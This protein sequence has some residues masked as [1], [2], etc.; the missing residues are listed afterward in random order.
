MNIC[1]GLNVLELGAGST[2]ASMAGMV[3][4][5]A[6]ARVIKVEPPSGDRLRT[7]LPSAFL[8]WNR[9]KESLVADLRTTE[10][11]A[12]VRRF[13]GEADVVLEGFSPGTTT[14]WG[15]GPTELTALNSRLVHCSITAFGPTG[16]YA[17]LK[18]YE[19]LVAAKSGLFARGGFGFR[20]G[21][22][23]SPVPWAGFGAAMQSVA[24]VLGALMVRDVTGRG[25]QLG[26]TMVG[27]LEPIDYFMATIVQ[28]MKKKGVDAPMDARDSTAASRFGVLV[29][30]RDGRFIQTSTMLP[31]QGAAL[32]RVAGLEGVL[33]DPRFKNQPRFATNED[34]QAW[35]DLLWEAFR[36][37][38]LAYWRA[39]LD[40]T[41][42]VAFEI[43]ATSEESLDHPQIV[44]NGDVITVDDPNVGPIR[45]VGPIG[46]FSETPL[47][48]SRSAPSLGV[49][50]GPFVGS[51]TQQPTAVAEGAAPPAHPLSGLTIVEFGY[52]YAMPYGLAMAASMGAR[53]IKLEDGKGDP[54]RS[55]FGP[56]V[57]S[58]KTTAAKESL[59]VDLSSEEGQQIAQRLMATADVFVTSFRTGVAEKLG[60]GWQTLRQIN[61][62]LLYVHAAGYGTDGPYARRALYA[63]A[64]QAV[65]G[66]F[67]RQVAFWSAPEN[68]VGM[69]V[70]ELQAIVAPRLGQ[71][72]D[73][74]SNAALGVLAAVTLGAYH[75]R[76]TG[77]G[78]FLMTSMIGSN[79]WAYSDDFNHYD[80]KPPLALCDSEYFGINALYRNYETAGG[81][82]VTL[83]LTTEGEWEAL[84]GS[85]GIDGLGTDP[86]FATAEGRSTHDRELIALLEARLMDRNASDWEADLNAAGVGCVAA[87]M[88]GHA[89][90]NS[91]DPVLR[92]TGLTVP[93]EHPLFGPMWRAAPPVTFS[94]TPG[95]VAPP[96]MR[97]EHNHA[98]L[99]ELGYSAEEIKGFEAILAIIP[100]A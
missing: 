90:F 72:T 15:I 96:C 28:L 56:E 24:G 100:P 43:S 52:F 64:A 11:Q 66:S 62:R 14:A 58:N 95:R 17:S 54:H 21:A 59:S 20:P 55:S 16:A 92:E 46:H 48:A 3:L 33:D 42:D 67:G 85:I 82:W 80:G 22:I 91:Y 84:V 9:G 65:G 71:V 23:M 75:Q 88:G 45:E 26:A 4:A 44:H 50:E 47:T 89:A 79:A 19:A 41:T 25:Q 60:L 86:R 2:G 27:G 8:V 83:A 5:D 53:V 34:A 37:E 76:R 6:G 35:E 68:N 69:S 29:A 99:S 40:Q 38:D 13:A 18:G 87:F 81:T 78:Q 51:Q 63:Q 10:G 1:E 77:Q 36:Q 94:E 30:T 31:H 70:L 73:G 57:A 97:G 32:A 61:P 93:F 7:Q 39:R 74:D 12:E 98:I 49:N